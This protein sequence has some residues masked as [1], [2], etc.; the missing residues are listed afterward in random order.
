MKPKK[1][2]DGV[3]FALDNSYLYTK[4]FIELLGKSKVKSNDEIIKSLLTRVLLEM[5]NRL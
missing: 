1:S 2:T 4:E 5:E 3:Q